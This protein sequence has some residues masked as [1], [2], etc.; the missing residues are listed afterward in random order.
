[1]EKLAN[2]TTTFVAVAVTVVILMIVLVV[3][4]LLYRR[5]QALKLSTNILA[6]E[7]QSQSP[8][9][10]LAEQLVEPSQTIQVSLC[11]LN[12]TLGSNS[13]K[14]QPAMGLICTILS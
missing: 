9:E 3:A 13:K 12:I 4:F 11:W 2:L 14:T 6:V 5:R 1:M 10:P 7:T 8:S